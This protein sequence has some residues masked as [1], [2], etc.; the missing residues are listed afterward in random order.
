MVKMAEVFL[1]ESVNALN[2]IGVSVS[3]DEGEGDVRE[4]RSLSVE[5]K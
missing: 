3:V 1:S 4:L 2:D 5:Y